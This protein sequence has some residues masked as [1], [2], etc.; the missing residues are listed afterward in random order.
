RRNLPLLRAGHGAGRPLWRRARPGGPILRA[1]ARARGL[2]VTGA[3]S[4]DAVV[5]CSV[6]RRGVATLTLNRPDKGNSYN[7][8]LLD[9][10][11]GEVTR[12]GADPAGRVH[13]LRA[14]GNQFS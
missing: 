4:P 11:S 9:A 13:A 10:L 12:L 7:Q 6:D 3:S 14:N 1:H 8:A 5:L 2:V